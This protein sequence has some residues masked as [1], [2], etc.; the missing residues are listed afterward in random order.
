MERKVWALGRPLRTT[1]ALCKMNVFKQLV[2][3]CSGVLVP[4]GY[5]IG[6]LLSAARCAAAYVFNIGL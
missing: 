5:G 4:L 3:V 6:A 1:K 2:E